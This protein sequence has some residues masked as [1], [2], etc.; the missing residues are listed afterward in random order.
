MI[1]FIIK[2][3]TI[4]H[5]QFSLFPIFSGQTLSPHPIPLHLDHSSFNSHHLT[6]AHIFSEEIELIVISEA[7]LSIPW[8][9]NNFSASFWIPQLPNPCLLAGD[10]GILFHILMVVVTSPQGLGWSQSISHTTLGDSNAFHWCRVKT[11]TPPLLEP[12]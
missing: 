4:S 3:S 1:I 6:A 12:T 8:S 2:T 9:L 7:F 5:F 11:S 10:P